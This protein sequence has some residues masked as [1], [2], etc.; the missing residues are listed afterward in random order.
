MYPVIS[1]AHGDVVVVN[2]EDPVDPLPVNIRP[3]INNVTPPYACTLTVNILSRA[4][5]DPQYSVKFESAVVVL[6]AYM[7]TS[8]M[9]LVDALVVCTRVYGAADA[10]TITELPKEP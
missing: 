1:T 3:G 9:L 7:Y 8:S 6:D 4:A 2:I 5:E 10:D